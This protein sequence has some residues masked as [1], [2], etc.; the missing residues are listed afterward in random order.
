MKKKHQPR[1]IQFR[2]KERLMKLESG[3]SYFI[4][5]GID[6]YMNFPEL[7]NA[8]K[9][10]QE[11]LSVLL[12]R[13]DIDQAFECY[14]EKATREA[15][16]ALFDKVK[17]NI[18]EKDKLLIY[19]SGHGHLDEDKLGYWIPHNAEMGNTANYIRNSTLQ[20]Y[21]RVIPAKHILLIS[22]SCY[23]GSLFYPGG[24]KGQK[25][26]AELVRYKSRW[27]LCSGRAEVPDGIPGT[28]SPFASS[29][30]DILHKNQMPGLNISKLAE[31]VMEMTGANGIQL[32][33][34]NPVVGVGHQGGQY[35]FI[36]KQYRH[37]LALN[38]NLQEITSTQ[39][40]VFTKIKVL[41]INF[42]LIPPGTSP[43]GREN[44]V[45]F[46]IA[47]TVLSTKQWNR[48]MQLQGSKGSHRIA[49]T[50]IS[51]EDIERFVKTVNQQS[52]IQYMLGIPE[53]SQLLYCIDFVGSSKSNLEN[54]ALKEG[55]CTKHGLYDLTKVVF[56]V[57]KSMGFYKAVGGS[58]LN[59]KEIRAS[60]H[61]PIIDIKN[62][63][64]IDPLIGFRPILM[65]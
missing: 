4:G 48:V 56:Q 13:Y 49:K 1:T 7:Y 36:L 43:E 51:V 40:E 42:V 50:S 38:K 2:G 6:N 16:I 58:Y 5:I 29:I 27:A 24:M 32:P 11:V 31:Q 12:N 46:Y 3:R 59:G 8:V 47:E 45:P 30:L 57:C 25:I 26:I 60:V 18:T 34:G 61:T 28:N 10:V 20:D 14:N 39:K 62:T 64:S 37:T 22:D 35:I 65:M 9:D 53:I 52:I 63:F 55:Q 19:Y 41:G 54:A 15:I 17:R 44:K 33:Q 21:I 23:S